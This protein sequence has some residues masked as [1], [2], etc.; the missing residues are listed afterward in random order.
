MAIYEYV[1]PCHF[2]LEAV[3]KKEITELGL[4]I[5]SV[6]DG[7]VT[8][9]GGEG[10]VA[11]AN[12]FLRT[13][14][15]VLLLVAK[16]KAETFDELFEKTKALPWEDFIPRDG[17]FWVAKATSVKSKLFSASDIQ[18]IMKK[19]VVERLKQKYHQDWFAE[20]GAGYP[21]RVTIMKDE[22]AVGI[23]TSGESLHKR[24]Y[25]RLASR[26]P[27]TETLAAALIALTPWKKDRVLVDPFC[28]SGTIPIEAAMMGQNIAPGRKRTFLAE[29]WKNL[30]PAMHFA[31]AR[32]EADDMVLRDV[33]L[34]IQ[35]YDI[36]RDIVDAARQNAILAGVDGQIHFQAKPVAELSSPKKFGFIVTNPPYGERME[37]KTAMPALYREIGETFAKLDTWS[38][39]I[40]TGFEDA[41]KYIG[42]KADKNRKIYNGMMKT[43]FYQFQGPKPPKGGKADR[44][45]SR[46]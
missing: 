9:R 28:G 8:Y 40:I 20:T 39:Y 3:L 10:A 24:G 32:E 6:E 34:S 16:F 44:A 11:R 14:E 12:T 45:E 4:E 37:E 5:V 22:V 27:L 43:Y 35:G 1:S 7:R 13:T 42:R 19:A 41:Q 38:Y 17:K 29:Q 21:I 2:G 26:A 33:T 31:R 23:D 25:R 36:D 15:R 18:S 30:I 46:L